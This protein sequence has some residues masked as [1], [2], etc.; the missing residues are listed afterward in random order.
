MTLRIQPVGPSML[1]AC[2]ILAGSTLTSQASAQPAETKD[3][4]DLLKG[5]AAA[6]APASKAARTLVKRDYEG[7]LERLDIRPEPAAIAML[8]LDAPTRRAADD[9]TRH[10]AAQIA[11]ALKAHRALLLEIQGANQAG[12]RAGAMPKIREFRE[13]AP[14][15]FEPPLVDRYV[16]VLPPD[17]VAEF[18][19]LVNEYNQAFIADQ[20]AE[21]PQGAA[22]QA[23]PEMQA[24]R[25][26][27]MQ[28]IREL[29]QTLG[30][31]VQER[32]ERLD[33]ALLAVDASPEVGEKIRAII[34]KAAES[35]TDGDL[36]PELR[37]QTNQQIMELLTPEQRRLWMQRLRDGQ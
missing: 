10:R 36:T 27:A 28:T 19:R 32:R 2:F 20:V 11:A 8:D 22:R 4:K 9:I 35:T 29:A 26:E 24:R 15:L 31:T 3:E 16:A 25:L 34:R 12:D 5:P 13:K 7:K 18:K 33:A 23:P 17:Q 37:R 30:A 6:E 1:F 21:R 14:D